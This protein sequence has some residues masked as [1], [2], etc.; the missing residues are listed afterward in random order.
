[1]QVELQPG[2][3]IFTGTPG[4]VKPGKDGTVNMLLEGVGKLEATLSAA[5][6]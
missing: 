6:E 1:M 5:P 2:D 4:P 3:V